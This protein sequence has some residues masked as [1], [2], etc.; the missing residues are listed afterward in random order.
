MLYG[1][2]MTSMKNI[3]KCLSIEVTNFNLLCGF[4]IAEY[5]TFKVRLLYM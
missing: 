5:E 2:E 1:Y 3:L 4:I